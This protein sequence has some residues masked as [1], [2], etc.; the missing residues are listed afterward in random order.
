MNF[1]QDR[2]AAFKLLAAGALAATGT[3][4]LSSSAWAYPAGQPALELVAESPD[5]VWNAVTLTSDNRMFASMPRWPGFADTPAVVEIMSDGTLK[6]YPGNG[7]NDWR[8]GRN[9]LN[10]FVCV[11]T[12]HCFDGRHLWILDTGSVPLS[13]DARQVG[14]QKLVQIDTRT[15]QVV[16]TYRFDTA[17]PEGSSLNDLRVTKEK[18]YMTESD[19][20]AIVVIDRQ[21]GTILRRLGDDPST[22]ALA[23]RP[24]IGPGGKWMTLPNGKPQMTNAD[25][26]ELSPDH[27]WLYY[28]PASG[29]LFRVKTQY[30]NDATLSEA[31]LGKH[32]EYV[33]DSPTL[34]G[35]AMDDRGN[36]F[37]AESARPRISVLAPDGTLRI[38]VEDE[39]LWGADAL[40]I[41]PDR[42]LY[43]PMSQVPNLL[44][45]QGV[46]GKDVSTRP[47]KI[48][49]MKLSSLYGGPISE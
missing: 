43:I 48:F 42:Y 29:P 21:S 39:R 49:R 15:D 27:R 38:V 36:I 28:S 3:V 26:I 14:A 30:L 31:D 12:V 46:N 11:N 25:P 34:G 18:I 16:K 6:P 5:Y 22:K 13:T 40:F 8:P 7:Y 35:T 10:A 2:R 44:F 17:L 23:S 19:I 45:S 9:A 47:F 33:Y 4:S 24:K 20:G 41:T 1:R 37:F 32:V